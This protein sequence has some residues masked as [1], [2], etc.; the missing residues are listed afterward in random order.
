MVESLSVRSLAVAA[1]VMSN[2]STR[3]FPMVLI[4]TTIAKVTAM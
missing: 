1:G 4:E 3:M 2:D